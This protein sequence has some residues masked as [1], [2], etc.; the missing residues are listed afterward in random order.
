M[1]II[2][3]HRSIVHTSRLILFGSIWVWCSTPAASGLFCQ[4]LDKWSSFRWCRGCVRVLLSG[5]DYDADIG[6]YGCSSHSGLTGAVAHYLQRWFASL[7][8]DPKRC[9]R[10]LVRLLRQSRRR[11]IVAEKQR[12]NLL[13]LHL[14]LLILPLLYLPPW[15]GACVGENWHLHC[16]GLH[17][18]ARQSPL[19]HAVEASGVHMGLG[20]EATVVSEGPLCPRCGGQGRW[21]DVQ[22]QTPARRLEALFISGEVDMDT[23]WETTVGLFPTCCNF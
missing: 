3:G 7:H 22:D 16:D 18:L 12:I 6:A 9:K 4:N 15:Y 19:C 20:L 8:L 13:E 11:R 23:F 10:C 21:P 17:Q 5:A 1:Q 14:V 2:T